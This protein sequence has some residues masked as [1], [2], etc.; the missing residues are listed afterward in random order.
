[1]KVQKNI[2]KTINEEISNFDFL[3]N[4]KYE[5]LMENITLME[6]EDFQ[7]QFI[8]DFLIGKSEKYE[9]VDSIEINLIG[10]W[11]GEDNQ[12]TQLGVECNVDLQYTYDVDKE[13]I[14][15]SLLFKSDSI[16][17]TSNGEINWGDVD[18]TLFTTEGDEIKF[19]T[20]ESAPE[21]IREIF[22]REFINDVFKEENGVSLPLT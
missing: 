17:K 8:V 9:I 22:I 10:D 20:F 16:S 12:E 7:K 4:D 5:M 13:P 18:V 21:K 11:E 19:T 15:F 6:N 2:I 3:G 1:M 14:E